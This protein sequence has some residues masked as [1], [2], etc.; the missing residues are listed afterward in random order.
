MLRSTPLNPSQEARLQQFSC[1]RTVD[2]HCHVLPGVDDGPK[3]MADSLAMC[4]ALIADGFTDIIATPHQLGR[5]DGSNPPITIRGVVADLQTQ[6]ENSRLPLT[7]HAGAE[8][9][10]DERIPQLLGA[11][12]I[13][14]LA[15]NGIHLLVELP[16]GMNLDPGILVPFITR[17][18]A[19]LVL[20][21]PE[22][23]DALMQDL[24]LVQRWVQLGAALQVNASTLCDEKGSAIAWD[25]LSR[26]WVALVAT[27]AHSTN[28]RRPRMSEAMELIVSRLGEDVARRVCIENPMRVLEGRELMLQG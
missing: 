25:W 9:R 15:D 24:L 18:G 14:T 12:K 6:L 1:V 22:R 3:T 11:G 23:Y 28:T 2:M 26:G 4:R 20:A 27:D 7:I 8:V 10:L 5:W 17:T 16:L 21:H 19:K 13:L